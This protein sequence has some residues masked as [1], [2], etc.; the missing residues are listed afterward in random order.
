MHGFHSKTSLD[1][2]QNFSL[3]LFICFSQIFPIIS[4]KASMDSFRNSTG[5]SFRNR[6]RDIFTD[7]YKHFLKDAFEYLSSDF[8]ENWYSFERTFSGI[9]SDIYPAIS[10]KTPVGM[11][12]GFSAE[13]PLQI[14]AWWFS[15]IRTE[16]HV[17]VA[18]WILPDF[19]QDFFLAHIEKLLHVFL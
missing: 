3:D 15:V 2:F 17:E 14:L 10:L 13:C 9:L 7:Y 5:G 8:F 19:R 12:Q 11:F 18:S 6:F 4:G 16:I 1:S